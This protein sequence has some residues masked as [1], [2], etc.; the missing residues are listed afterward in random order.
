MK[1]AGRSGE[2]KETPCGSLAR[3][4]GNSGGARACTPNGK[5]KW[6]YHSN[7]S[8]FGTVQSTLGVGARSRNIFFGH[9]PVAVRQGQRRDAVATGEERNGRFTAGK[10]TYIQLYRHSGNLV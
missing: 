5:A 8:S 2:A 7:L 10:S 6:C 3:E 4:T 9:V 1:R